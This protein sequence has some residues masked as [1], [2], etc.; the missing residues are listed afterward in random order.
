MAK[1][2]LVAV[3]T[4]ADLTEQTQTTKLEDAFVALNGGVI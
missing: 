2:K 4:V 1:G 3:G